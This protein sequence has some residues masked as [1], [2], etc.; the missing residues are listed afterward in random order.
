MILVLMAVVG[1]S[2]AAKVDYEN[3]FSEF[4]REFNATK[5]GISKCA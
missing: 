3:M 2:V 4:M 5:F 1:F